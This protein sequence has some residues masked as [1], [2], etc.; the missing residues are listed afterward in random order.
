MGVHG[1]RIV[2]VLQPA[3]AAEG[4]DAREFKLRAGSEAALQ[5]WLRL[6]IPLSLAAAP[7]PRGRHDARRLVAREKGGLLMRKAGRFG[8]A[9]CQWVPRFFRIDPINGTLNWYEAD[10]PDARMKG[11]LRLHGAHIGRCAGVDGGGGGGGGGS[12]LQYHELEVRPAA[13]ARHNFEDADE[14]RDAGGA[15]HFRAASE[16]ELSDWLSALVPIASHGVSAAIMPAPPTDGGGGEAAAAA[17]AAAAGTAGGGGGVAGGAMARS[18]GSS[19]RITGRRVKS[20]AARSKGWLMRKEGGEGPLARRTWKRRYFRLDPMSGSLLAY[21]SDEP[22]QQL[23]GAMSV[24]R[25]CRIA[26]TVSTS[27]EHQFELHR[28]HVAGTVQ[29]GELEAATDAAWHLRAA[30]G[31]ELQEWLAALRGVAVVKQ[32]TAREVLRG[33]GFLLKKGAKRRNWKRRWFKLGG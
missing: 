28:A 22:D 4:F 1:G 6:L 29:K 16:Q 15:Y 19:R 13:V 21:N 14:A 10:L 5:S 3:E 32:R 12:E 31:A 18:T 25:G 30:D 33:E 23:R 9:G 27:H 7:Q 24:A 26:E 11:A 8:V 20:E 17:A 2:G